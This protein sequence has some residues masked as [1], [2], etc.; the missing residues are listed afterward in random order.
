MKISLTCVEDGLASVGVRKMASLMKHVCPD[1]TLYYVPYKN[2]RNLREQLMGTHGDIGDVPYNCIREIASTIAQADLVCFS[3]M[4]GYS[5]LTKMIMEQ[6]RDINPRAYILWGGI[7]PIIVPEDAILH[8]DAICTGEGEFA[9]LEFF[10]AFKEGRDYTETENFWFRRGEEIIR[11]PFRPLMSGEDMARFPLPAYRDG[12]MIYQ[13]G[14]GFVPLGT[15]HHLEHNA[16]A[17]NTVWSIG[18]PFKC[19]YCGNTK[20]IENDSRYRRVRHPP[21]QHIIN[22]FKKVLAAEPHISV[23]VFHDDSFMAL[24]TPMLAEFARKY[25]KQIGIPFV[26]HGV[27]PNYVKE[28][29][30]QILLGAGL[31]RIRMG[32]QNGSERMLKFYERP[33]PVKD[34]RRAAELL[35][36]YSRYMI[37]PAYDIIVD[38]PL[39]SKQDVDDN[40]ILLQGLARPFTLNVFS[41]R[42][43]PN[44]QLEKQMENRNISVCSIMKG[45]AHNAPTLANCLLY[46]LGIFRLPE[47]L[48]QWMLKWAKPLTQDQKM[49]PKVNILCRAAYML[50]RGF[51]HLR[52]LDFSILPGKVGYI[53]WKVGILNCFRERKQYSPPE[54][55]KRLVCR[56]SSPSQSI[57]V[58]Q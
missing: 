36:R 43:I 30:L 40:L 19:S 28:T 52:F 44:T 25:K 15:R 56:A 42:V 13:V 21:V 6:V 55:V 11:N 14:Q 29:K 48:F 12:E 27:I 5:D 7:H 23:M 35:S 4:T 32:I 53:F 58:L 3:C 22:E 54:G 26:V 41:L 18:C 17:Y 49:Y 46:L 45:Y 8:A 34:I 24:P 51:D 31:N 38:N 20:F 47:P 9:F 37:P 50:K 2:A 33:T 1:T 16:L 57:R 10:Q 39:E